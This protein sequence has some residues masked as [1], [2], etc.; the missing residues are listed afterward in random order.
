MLIEITTAYIVVVCSVIWIMMSGYT[1]GTRLVD[2][3]YRFLTINVPVG[4]KKT[5]SRV[6]GQRAS[7]WIDNF[8]DYIVYQNN[9]II[10]YFYLLLLNVG[11]WSF[12]WTSFPLLPNKVAE[13]SMHKPLVLLLYFGCLFVFTAATKADPGVINKANCE[14]YMSKYM[15]DQFIFKSA[16]EC[17]TCKIVK[18]ARSKHCRLC[19]VCVARYDHHCVWLRTCIGAG[20][21]KW[22]LAFL[23]L[24]SLICI[25][26]VYMSYAVLWGEV[27]ERN[28]LNAQFVHAITKKL[29]K[30]DAFVIMNFMI[31]DYPV[32][33]AILILCGLL[34]IVLPMFLIYH[35]NLI[36]VNMTTNETS[37]WSAVDDPKAFN[38]YNNGLIANF[39]EVLG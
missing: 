12:I 34:S 17:V 15:F 5:V 16:S 26:G 19:G 30:S 6:L 28:L 9:P 2:K 37:K 10:M 3:A 21:L 29:I 23:L 31:H 18:P 22:F 36:R 14:T 4:M 11:V 20:N 25:Y 27:L 38:S 13:S 39:K 33:V 7:A 8:W 35:L 24:H 32:P 1:D